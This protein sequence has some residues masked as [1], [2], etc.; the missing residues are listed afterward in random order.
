MREM[1]C[2]KCGGT[3]TAVTYYPKGKLINHSANERSESEF[4][5]SLQYNYY[6]NI[7]ADKEHL[8]VHCRRCQYA[9]DESCGEETP[10]LLGEDRE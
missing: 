1:K 10:E 6:W 7:T 5:Y 3:D 4:H 9:W 2:T 8:H